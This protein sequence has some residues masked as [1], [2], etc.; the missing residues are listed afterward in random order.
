MLKIERVETLREPVTLKLEGRV[1]GPWVEELRR[2]CE[3]VLARHTKLVLDL[4]EVSFVD[5]EGVALLL[6]LA[7]RHVRLASCSR[8]VA[9]QLKASGRPCSQS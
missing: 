7:D 5:L 4:A 1:I 6:G 8:F 3:S 2:S 9:E